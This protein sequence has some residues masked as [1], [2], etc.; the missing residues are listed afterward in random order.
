M[1]KLFSSR[2]VLGQ[3]HSSLDPQFIWISPWLG[4]KAIYV[5]TPYS[6]FWSAKV[7][8]VSSTFFVYTLD[9]K[10]FSSQ[11]VLGQWHSSLDPQFI[12]ISPW[13]GWK[14][15]YVETLYSEFESEIWQRIEY[16]FGYHLDEKIILLSDCTRAVTPLPKPSIHLI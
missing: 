10:L 3:W 8:N 12:W 5:E 16:F 14:A 9:Q 2:T 4:W 7:D 11:I 13:L 15:I 1:K 6:E